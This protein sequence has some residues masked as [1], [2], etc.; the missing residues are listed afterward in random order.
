M[1]YRYILLDADNTLYD[2][3]AAEHKALCF[4]LSQRGYATDEKTINTYLD[5]NNTLWDAFARGEV[6]QEFLLVERFRR[7]IQ[8]VGGSHDPAEMNRD[9]LN[10][11]GRNGDLIFGAEEFCRQLSVMG[12]RLAIVTNGASVAQRGRYAGSPLKQYIPDVFISQEMG[13]NKPDPLF[14]DLV[15]RNMEIS[16]RRD[17]VVVGDSL[18]SD[19]LGGN[20]AGIDT[21]WYNPNQRPL[22]GEARPTFTATDYSEILDLISGESKEENR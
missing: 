14:F 10:A 13:V 4:V 8:T 1:K 9:Y 16:D 11:I 22:D 2:F 5:I 21:I 18:I 19:I 20:R 17:A 3:D 7:F 12:C 15:C 6:T